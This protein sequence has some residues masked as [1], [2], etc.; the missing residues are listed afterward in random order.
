MTPH[1]SRDSR[2]HRQVS[3]WR[4][5][6][7]AGLLALATLACYAP[8]LNAGYIWDDDSYLTQNPLVQGGGE[9]IWRIWTTT[10]TPQYYPLVF[11]SFWVEH[12]LWG[13]HPTGYHLVNVLLHLANAL[14]VW[15]LALRLRI[16]AAWLIGAIF[17]LHPVHVESVAWVTERKNVLSGLFFLLSL[18]QMLV[19]HDTRRASA[20]LLALA[21]FLAALLSKSVTAMLAPSLPLILWYYG[22]RWSWMSL[23]ASLPLVL[24]G[25]AK[26]LLTARLE[27]D[28]VGASGAEWSQSLLERATLIAPSAF[29]FY[30]QKILLPYPLIFAYPRWDIGE[31][32]VTW[33]IPL[34]L[35]LLALLLAV[36]GARRWGIGPAVLIAFSAI[37]LFP[38][39]GFLNVYPHR[40]SYVADHFQYLG[41]LGFIVLFVCVALALG[42]A[43]IPPALRQRVGVT[44]ALLI[45]AGLGWRT[46]AEAREYRDA[47]T[48]WV[49]TLRDN[50]DAWLAQVN[51]GNSLRDQAAALPAGD[52]RRLA[53]QQQAA[54]LF[55]R[56]TRHPQARFEAYTGLGN[57]AFQR[58][59]FGEAVEHFRQAVAYAPFGDLSGQNNLAVA[60]QSAG[61]ID[62]S[63]AVLAGAI[64][65]NP[66]RVGSWYNLSTVLYAAGRFADAA[67]AAG[68]AAE[69]A[70]ERPDLQLHYANLLAQAG[71]HSRAADAYSHFLSSAG[72]GAATAPD[73]VRQDAAYQRV[74]NLYDGGRA[75]EALRLA[76]AALATSRNDLRMLTQLIWMLAT[77]PDPALRDAGRAAGLAAAIERNGVEGAPPQVLD[78]LA[79][80]A[81]ASGDYPK[82]ARLARMAGEAARSSGRRELAQQIEQR[83]AEYTAGRPHVHQPP[84]PH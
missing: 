43:L 44:A 62:E 68:W 34:A 6:A 75:T 54:D 40:Y 7:F 35:S 71:Y 55:Q 50:P 29:V 38:A 11:S 61:R 1:T 83:I 81:A 47:D 63:L 20:Y 60:L 59:Q 32:T 37:N 52:S 84:P 56:A 48:L 9:A 79:A 26:G 33:Y 72:A 51:L 28:K 13:L 10:Q 65:S 27:A 16:P 23:W 12:K 80:A 3:W 18:R 77:A 82:A 25:A 24:I 2:T 64:E 19:W 58:E 31:A 46:F 78:A 8:A 17:A 14:L 30:A 66:R 42:R 74:V 45:T 22:R 21:C 70:P 36:A 69:L 39:L 4:P 49:A 15:R 53:L 41:S 76:E 67:G 5:F 73:Y 57:V